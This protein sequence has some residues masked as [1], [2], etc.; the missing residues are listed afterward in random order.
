MPVGQNEVEPVHGEIYALRSRNLSVGVYVE[1]ERGFIG[2]REKFGNE[3][4]FM[5][6]RYDD[7]H[8]HATAWATAHLGTVPTGIPLREYLGSTCSTCGVEV[9]Y[10]EN[11]P[12]AVPRRGYWVH[13]YDTMA[14]DPQHSSMAVHNSALFRVLKPL[15]DAEW[16]RR[17][18]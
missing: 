12:G 15:S 17:A 5:E 10:M 14:V 18:Y 1:S 11:V 6:Y 9:Q 8:A 7:N 13:L 4:L 2:V 3:F 16:E